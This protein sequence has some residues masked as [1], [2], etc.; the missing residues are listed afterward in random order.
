MAFYDE[1]RKN[2]DDVASMG[3]RNPQRGWFKLSTALTLWSGLLVCAAVP[4]RANTYLFSFTGQEILDAL[5]DPSAQ[6][7]VTEQES[8]YFGIWLQPSVASFSY[9]NIYSPNPTS[10]QAWDANTIND[11]A[12]LGQSGT[13]AGF[14]KLSNTAYVAVLSDANN[15]GTAANNIF[16]NHNYT[17]SGT[18][19]APVGWGSNTQTM[20]EIMNTSALF[21]FMIETPSALTGPVTVNGV[22]SALISGS[23]NIMTAGTKDFPALDF[24]L[25][26][27]PQYIPEPDSWVLAVAGFGLLFGLGWCRKSR[28]DSRQ[29]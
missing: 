13:F 6:G 7:F 12:D 20:T 3:T 15:G 1:R 16:L 21:K 26:E 29:S 25:T 17:G 9:L 18:P 2:F 24:T 14:N 11:P 22:A 5:K 27:T 28:R 4:A 10:Q 19:A 23:T 8:A